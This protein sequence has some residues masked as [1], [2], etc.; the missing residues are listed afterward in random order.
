MKDKHIGNSNIR[1][2]YSAIFGKDVD[3]ID[4]YY[5]LKPIEILLPDSRD[6]DKKIYDYLEME[7]NMKNE[8]IGNPKY[9]TV[10]LEKLSK[11]ITNDNYEDL[12]SYPENIAGELLH[13]IDQLKLINTDLKTKVKFYEKYIDFLQEKLNKYNKQSQEEL[14]KK[15]KN[16]TNENYYLREQLKIFKGEYDRW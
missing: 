12:I 16:L 7:E 2:E 8:H 15:I 3:P 13:Y 5:V 14:L 1:F 11:E 6:L 10:D 4:C 9:T